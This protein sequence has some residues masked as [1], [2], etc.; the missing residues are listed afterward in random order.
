VKVGDFLGHPPQIHILAPDDVW[1][2]PTLKIGVEIELEN[3]K[4]AL[5]HPA[6]LEVYWAIEQDGS[7]R[8]N[9]FELVLKDPLFGK[10]LT[11]AVDM[12]ETWVKASRTVANYRTGLHIHMDSRALEFDELRRFFVLYAL[13]EKC[14][15]NFVGDDRNNSNFCAPWYRISDHL[16]RVFT[17][18]DKGQSNVSMKNML[19]GVER[20]SALNCSALSKY[21]SVEFRHM[22]MTMDFDKIRQW[23]N[24]IMSLHNAA[25]MESNVGPQN[26]STKEL[27]GMAAKG[28]A[29]EI[30][31]KIFPAW[32]TKFMD[33]K[34]I[35]EGIFLAQGVSTDIQQKWRFDRTS[36]VE[37]VCP[38]V[39]L[40][41]PYAKY[42]QNMKESA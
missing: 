20:Y 21:G 22:Q 3:P 36:I 39:E 35:W 14:L 8:D 9:G 31:R 18:F 26:M 28:G 33:D 5:I 41:R 30:A 25:G 24:L 17:M 32:F 23:I 29:M 2:A 7:L 1:V 4:G 38:R 10:D 40:G 11:K 12:M 13:Y 6:G 37:N 16:D 19:D 27:L 15:F 42:L 34:S